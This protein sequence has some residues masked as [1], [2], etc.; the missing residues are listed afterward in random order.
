MIK[1]LESGKYELVET[2][3]NLRA[4]ILPENKAYLWK[5]SGC[6]GSLQQAN[7]DTG[8][9]CCT[10]SANNYR[11]YDVINEPNLTKGI[12]LELYAGRGKWQSYLLSNGLPTVKEKK[13]SLSKIDEVITKVRK[14]NEPITF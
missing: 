5:N 11:L 1:L 3:N 6:T 2:T 10:L 7:F 8:N 14:N 9:I 12:H 4:L 13:K